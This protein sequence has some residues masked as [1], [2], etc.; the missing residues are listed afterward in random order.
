[1]VRCYVALGSN[2]GDR[3]LNLTEARR[4]LAQLGPL[5]PGPVVETPAVLPPG[6][7][8]AQP[9]YLNSVDQ[10]DASLSAPALHRELTRIERQM[11]RVRTTRWAP[12]IIDLDLIFYGD[13]VIETPE[14]TVPHPSMHER[15]FVL[16][17][18]VA[19]A[20]DVRHPVLHRTARQLLDRL[21]RR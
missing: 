2:L 5:L 10:L 7:W 19:L 12:R 18:L 21:P 9:K 1:M 3:L 11:G 16:E 20:P 17:P 8:I 6:D 4:R 15:R 14:L 13:R